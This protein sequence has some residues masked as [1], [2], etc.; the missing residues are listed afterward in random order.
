[1]LKQCPAAPIHRAQR[2]QVRGGDVKLLAR[3]LPQCGRNHAHRFQQSPRQAQETDLQRQCDLEGGATALLDHPSLVAGKREERLD[4][5]VAQITRQTHAAPATSTVSRSCSG[6]PGRGPTMARQKAEQQPLE[7]AMKSRL[8]L[9]TY[10]EILPALLAAKSREPRDR[11]AGPCVRN[12]STGRSAI[13]R[14]SARPRTRFDAR[15]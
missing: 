15:R 13:A 14:R 5:D 12:A 3:V 1:M 2:R 6:P 9:Y 11:P 4:L 10:R 7:S 8:D